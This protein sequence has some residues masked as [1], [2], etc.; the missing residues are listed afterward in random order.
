MSLFWK[1]PRTSKHKGVWLSYPVRPLEWLSKQTYPSPLA[2]Q[3]NSVTALRVIL[4]VR[5]EENRVYTSWSL[6]L[7][8]PRGIY[9][10]KDAEQKYFGDVRRVGKCWTIRQ[11]CS[12][13]KEDNGRTGRDECPCCKHSSALWDV[14]YSS[15]EGQVWKQGNRKRGLSTQKTFNSK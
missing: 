7:H 9:E 10:G 1:Q 2:P 13:S 5:G 4:C 15:R 14:T 3:E 11:K 6:G 12:E 8:E